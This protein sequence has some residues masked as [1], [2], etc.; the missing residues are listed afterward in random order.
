[1][2]LF[3]RGRVR[4]D[5]IV[6]KENVTSKNDVFLEWNHSVGSQDF[7]ILVFHRDFAEENKQIVSDQTAP[8]GSG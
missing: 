8:I 1:M 3:K 6:F 7:S 5:I 4:F 2:N